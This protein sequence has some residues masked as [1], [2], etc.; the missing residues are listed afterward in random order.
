MIEQG[1]QVIVLGDLNVSHRLID[2]CEPEDVTN[3][4]KTPPRQWLD[5]FLSGGKFVDAFRHL[6]PT[7]EKS[8]TCWNTKLNA[9]VNNYGTRIDYILLSSGL[10]S[11][12]AECEIMVDF[13]G[14]DHCPVRAHLALELKPS[15]KLPGL[16]TKHFKEFAGKQLK[17]SSFVV[18][19]S[20]ADPSSEPPESKKPKIA[21]NKG[22]QQSSLL[23]F[24]GQPKPMIESS[25]TETCFVETE[26]SLLSSAV[27]SSTSSSAALWKN[28]FKGIYFVMSRLTSK[29]NYS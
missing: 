28:V 14:S 23:K 7:K 17:M 5:G 2:H 20:L 21:V 3:F 12:L 25:S 11:T 15:D 4:S 9:R 18:K 22:K 16:C 19:R 27:S 1:Y 26:S 13:Q 29:N 8:F 24:F 10:V 6:Y